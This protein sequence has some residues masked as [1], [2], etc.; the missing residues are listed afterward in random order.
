MAVVGSTTTYNTPQKEHGQQQDEEWGGGSGEGVGVGGGGVK[1]TGDGGGGDFWS[2]PTWHLDA[3]K[4]RLGVFVNLGSPATSSTLSVG[5][6]GEETSRRP[7]STP[8]T[9]WE[10]V[11]PRPPHRGPRGGS[12][13]SS[14]SPAASPICESSNR[15]AAFQPECEEEEDDGDN[16]GEARR[17]FK[18]TRYVGSPRPEE[19]VSSSSPHVPFPAPS[20]RKRGS[21]GG[22]DGGGGGSVISE[23]DDG[24][25][26]SSEGSDDASSSGNSW[27]GDHRKRRSGGGGGRRRGRGGGGDKKRRRRGGGGGGGGKRGGRGGGEKEGAGSARRGE[28]Q[29]QCTEDRR[30][31]F[32]VR[33]RNDPGL[34]EVMVKKS[35][36]LTTRM[37]NTWVKDR[38]ERGAFYDV[39]TDSFEYTINLGKLLVCANTLQWLVQLPT[40]TWSR[41]M[42]EVRTRVKNR[43]GVFDA[44][45]ANMQE[46]VG[47]AG[48]SYRAEAAKAFFKHYV[49]MCDQLPKATRTSNKP[50]RGRARGS[51]NKT[52]EDME[53]PQSVYDKIKLV[54]DTPG[55]SVA[56]RTETY[57]EECGEYSDDDYSGDDG[58]EEE[59]AD[60][61][62]Y[63]GGG[64]DGGNVDG[65]GG[66]T[67]A[68]CSADAGCC[69]TCGRVVGVG[70]QR[71]ESSTEPTTTHFDYSV[72]PLEGLDE[73]TYYRLFDNLNEGQHSDDYA[74]VVVPFETK[75]GFYAEYVDNFLRT[76]SCGSRPLSY[77]AFRAL[78]KQFFPNVLHRKART[79]IPE[80]STCKTLREHLSDART[81]TERMQAKTMRSRHLRFQRDQRK[82]YYWHRLKAYEFPN[83]YILLLLLCLQI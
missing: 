55:G 18:R 53:V 4:P 16:D 38:V 6:V 17:P 54:L 73:A 71:D 29:C 43:E 49:S 50:R 2:S 40:S 58:D 67:D 36:T 32:C 8:A 22:S 81:D 51:K 19:E 31:A 24:E 66:C 80:C 13:S 76:D 20:K 64:K 78:W 37:L 75:A 10:Q 3:S 39:E 11:K 26:V 33:A 69:S 30:K 59:E 28:F 34:R 9:S 25:G 63:G 27:E 1:V 79:T 47:G 65:G 46:E 82:K 56:S 68:P 12:S 83:R 14:S 21:S 77:P 7:I 23:G 44:T 42:R 74:E 61:S 62:G 57:A 35:T 41:I 52:F 70:T 72:E 48:S 15:F 60:D 45:E 5:S